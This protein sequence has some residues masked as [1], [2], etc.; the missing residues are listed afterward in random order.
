[1]PGLVALLCRESVYLVAA[2]NFIAWTI[3]YYALEEWLGGFA[4][5]IDLNGAVFL[6]GSLF[7]LV[8]ALSTVSWQAIRA[9][10]THPIAAFRYE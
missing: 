9:A 4:Y 6:G 2:A 1:M 5:R 7:V 3:A 10:R 8:V